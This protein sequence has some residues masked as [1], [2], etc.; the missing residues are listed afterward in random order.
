MNRLADS[1]RQWLS[2]MRKI[3]RGRVSVIGTACGRKAF[4]QR[5]VRGGLSDEDLEA[6]PSRLNEGRRPSS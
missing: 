6:E 2:V 4:L 3:G 5:W 1:L